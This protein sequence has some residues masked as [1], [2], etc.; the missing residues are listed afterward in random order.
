MELLGLISNYIQ[1]VLN[2]IA[3]RVTAKEIYFPRK[4]EKIV[5]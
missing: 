2:Y 4:L 1:V 5:S 3:A